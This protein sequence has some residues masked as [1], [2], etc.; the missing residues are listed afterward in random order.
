MNVFDRYL[1][2]LF[3]SGIHIFFMGLAAWLERYDLM[4]LGA[5]MFPLSFFAF[6][7]V[8]RCAP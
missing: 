6:V 3:V 7:Y 2:H 5:L 8:A 4:A 1:V